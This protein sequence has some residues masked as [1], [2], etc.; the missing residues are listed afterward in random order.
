[1][2]QL[3]AVADLHLEQAGEIFLSIRRSSNIG[4]GFSDILGIDI[5]FRLIA[6]G[7]LSK[8]RQMEPGERSQ[9]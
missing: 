2:R 8:V 6:F 9:A 5:R 7:G 3:A 4:L 1:M